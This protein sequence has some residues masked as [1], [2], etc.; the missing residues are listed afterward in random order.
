MYQYRHMQGEVNAI[1][2]LDRHYHGF[3]AVKD[4]DIWQLSPSPVS[5]LRIKNAIR[6]M[7]KNNHLVFITV[8]DTY[9]LL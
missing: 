3:L 4:D 7:H 8:R 6:W 2:K 1:T 5:S 9:P